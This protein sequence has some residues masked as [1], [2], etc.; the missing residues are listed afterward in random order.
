MIISFSNYINLI[1]KV[2]KTFGFLDLE[3]SEA[4]DDATFDFEEGAPSLQKDSVWTAL[5]V[6]K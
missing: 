2:M 5:S 6:R 4:S 3:T 1:G